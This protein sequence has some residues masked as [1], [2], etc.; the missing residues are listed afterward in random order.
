MDVELVRQMLDHQ[1]ISC[2]VTVAKT[3]L[4]FRAALEQPQ[5]L[6]L[7]DFTLPGFTGLA[8]LKIAKEITPLVPLIFIS[9]TIGE[10]AAI[11]ALKGGATDYVLKDRP[12]RLAAAV[13]R[14]IKDAA[15]SAERVRAQEELKLSREQLRALAA[16]LQSPREKERIRIS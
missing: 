4:E 13:R 6:V 11:E 7:C 2:S 14:A 8:A 15:E 1:G 9:G 10:E 16:R 5:D 3:Q 12:A